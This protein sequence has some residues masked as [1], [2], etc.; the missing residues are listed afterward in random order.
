MKRSKI[1]L[2]T[3]G[4]WGWGNHTEELL[5]T[6]DER[7]RKAG[8]APPK[9]VDIRFNQAVRAKGFNGDNFK[10]LVGAKRYR[11][12]K[13]LGNARIGSGKG[14]IRI[15]EPQAAA[16]LL[17]EALQAADDNRRIIYFCACEVPACCHRR[18][19]ARLVEKEGEKRK[20]RVTNL[21][22]PGG[23][24]E[25]HELP[26]SRELFAKAAQIRATVPL[27]RGATELRALPWY[28]AVTFRS[29]EDKSCDP[30][31]IFTGPARFKKA[32]W[33]LPV[34]EDVPDCSRLEVMALARRW[35][36]KYGYEAP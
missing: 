10:E 1:T 30:I 34:F 7:E 18:T 8:Y 35:R 4:Y 9:F 19:V 3:F 29:K 23:D 36:K 13:S 31:T 2:F 22:W 5:S 27:P 11:H 12:M 24:P 28:S 26:V 15:K 33:C 6:I 21:E 14:G 16:E 17:D 25:F 20:L 32:R